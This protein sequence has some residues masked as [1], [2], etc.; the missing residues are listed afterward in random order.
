[1]APAKK[2]SARNAPA[3]KAPARKAP[4]R[5]GAAIRGWEDDPGEPSARLTP[6]AFPVPNLDSKPLPVAVLGTAPAPRAY[7]PGSAEF[8]WWAAAEALRRGADMWAKVVPAGLTW[9][10]TVGDRLEATLDAGE[11]FNAYYDRQGLKFFHGS[12]AGRLVYSGESPDVVCHELGHA[13][14]DAMKPQLF[15]R[16]FIEKLVVFR[17]PERLN[18]SR[19]VNG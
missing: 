2:A 4:G 16:S 18:P 15:G 14:L 11:D 17:L 19:T 5:R 8:R 3:R 10:P 6:V 12:V 1:M 9:F 7:S 13:V